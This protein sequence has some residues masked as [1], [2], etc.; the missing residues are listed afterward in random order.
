MTS[1]WFNPTGGFG[2]HVRA[3]LYGRRQWSPFRQEIARWLRAWAPPERELLLVGP[4]GGYS[5]DPA[6]LGAFSRIIAVDI[7][8]LAALVFRLRFG[9]LLRERGV[10]LAWD[11]RD[12][13]SPGPQGF[14]L[15]PL[16]SLVAAHPEAAVLF[17]NLLGQLPLLGDDRLPDQSDD[18]PP[19][20][21]Y[22]RWLLGLPAALA[23]RSWATYHDRISGDGRPR[24]L[25]EGA[26][27]PWS[28]SEDLVLH[29]FAPAEDR[30]E[31][32][33]LLDHRTSVLLRDT[34]REQFSWEI[35][36]GVF[37]L[38]EAFSFRSRAPAQALD[39]DR[40]TD[41]AT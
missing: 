39:D 7:D 24:S 8:P 19:E 34:P 15:Q 31:K 38:I 28:P 17:C 41:A 30:V 18:D 36:P 32:L 33:E 5:L 13:L 26:P 25:P 1:R 11:S 21:S 12:H 20:G 6:F 37:H 4:S 22:E 2:Y 3:L 9:R 27:V 14:S 10:A 40:G 16:C 29:H 35:A 23:G